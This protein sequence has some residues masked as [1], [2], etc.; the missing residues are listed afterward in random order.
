MP[1]ATSQPPEPSQVTALLQRLN[2]SADRFSVI[3][4]GPIHPDFPGGAVETYRLGNGL[5]VLLQI[6]GRAPVLS[7]NVWFRVGSRNEREGKTG[8]AHLFEHLM[9]NETKLLPAGRFDQMLERA[10]AETNAATWTDWTFYYENIPADQLPLVVKL[11][12]DRMRNLVL[13]AKP[14]ASEKEVVA[15]E[16]RYRVEDD[17]DG[18]VSETLWSLAFKEHPYHH[19]TIGWMTDIEN[20]TPADCRE[21]YKTWYAPNN[22][23]VVLVGDLDRAKALRLIQRYYGAMRPAKLPEVQVPREPLQTEHRLAVLERPTPTAKVALGFKCPEFSHPD[24]AALSV[25]VEA[26]T[27]G[28]SARL[29]RELVTEQEIATDISGWAS[30]FRDPGLVEISATGRGTVQPEA[31]RD[32]IE[33]CL[34]SVAADPISD[35]E[36]DRAVAR[37]ELGFLRGLET[38]GGRAESIGF[39]S[40]V[41]D[42][43]VGSVARMEAIRSLSAA[44]LQDVARRYLFGQPCTAVLVRSN[45]TPGAA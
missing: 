20:F 42:D 28:R 34:A 11:E 43:P 45:L 3:T 35:D 12:S 25:L 1:I 37:L 33:R 9:F 13:R 18:A 29:Y 24:H 32:A 23:T 17:V 30:T 7:Y 4:A 21:F 10:G 19:P 27:G 2:R 14:V 44:A 26:L 16:R 6:D 8:L 40:V 38:V 15:N 36:R 41:I 31:L 22:A 5:Q 39:H